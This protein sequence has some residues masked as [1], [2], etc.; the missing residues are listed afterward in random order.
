MFESDNWEDFPL[1]EGDYV[2]GHSLNNENDDDDQCVITKTPGFLKEPLFYLRILTITSVLSIS[3]QISQTIA[4][5][6]EERFFGFIENLLE[7]NEESNK[8]VI[9]SGIT[10]QVT[11]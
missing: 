1:R 3:L 9:G 11:N 10:D 5:T 7:R 2:T 8:R 6:S 4:N